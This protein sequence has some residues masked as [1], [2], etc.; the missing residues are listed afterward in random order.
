MSYYNIK[1]LKEEEHKII[2]EM[3]PILNSHS[4]YNCVC[5]R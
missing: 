4:K 5:G 3:Q 1:Q 2:E